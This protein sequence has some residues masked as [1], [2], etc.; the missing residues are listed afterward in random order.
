MRNRPWPRELDTYSALIGCNPLMVQGPGGNTSF[1]SEQELWV[2]ASGKRLSNANDQE[3]FV[4]VDVKNG[5]PIDS[6]SHLKPSIEKDFHLLIPFPYV[7]HTH[8]LGSI[9]ISIADDF[10]DRAFDYPDIAFVNYGR[11][12]KDL[13]T[14]IA[15]SLDFQIHKAA[16]LQNHGFLTWGDK[17]EDAYSVLENFEKSMAVPVNL[18]V[19]T[20]NAS[21]KIDHPKAITP[22]Y[23]VFLSPHTESEILDFTGANLWKKEMYL[24]AQSAVALTKIQSKINYLQDNEVIALQNWDAEKFRMAENK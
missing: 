21:L 9:A 19:T 2:K 13:C 14:L 17:I 11:P 16:I 24:V 10:G 7:I 8:S 5:L 20:V 12:G 22:D 1:K 15:Q 18:E 4:G 6:Q 23:A 3:I